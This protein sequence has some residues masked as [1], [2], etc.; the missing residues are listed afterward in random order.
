M[1]DRALT[2][3]DYRRLL[4]FRTGLRRFLRWSEE[5]AAEA[6]LTPAHHQLLL[7]VRGSSSRRGPTI[8]EVSSALLL[9]PHSAVGLMDR[10]EAGG[11]VRRVKDPRDRRVVRV[12]L[13]SRGARVLRRLSSRHLAELRRLAPTIRRLVG[14]ARSDGRLRE[15]G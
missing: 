11:L 14:P 15:P 9:R 8:G 5:Q 7:A 2:D 3:L 6:G 4:A 1:T 10:A 13:T 12:R